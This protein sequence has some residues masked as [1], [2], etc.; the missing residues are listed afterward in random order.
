LNL[1]DAIMV[2]ILLI[3]AILIGLTVHEFAHAFVADRLGDKTPKFQ[4]RLTLNP[5]VHIDLVGFVMIMLIGFGWAKPV[6]TNPSAYKRRYKDDIKVSIAGVVANFITALI[7]AL[8][9]VMLARIGFVTLDNYSTLQGILGNILSLIVSINCML[10]IFNLIPIPGLDGFHILRDL[11]PKFFY[12]ISDFM[13]RY[14]LFILLIFVITP[15]ASWLVG[16]PSN[17]LYYAFMKLGTLIF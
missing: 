17:L 13:Y 2:K 12:S 1:N 15:A 16:I 14:Q 4:G 10:C 11:F 9:T 7:F 5:F 6:E 3:P 8:L